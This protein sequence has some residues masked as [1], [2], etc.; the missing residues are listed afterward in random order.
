MSNEI[1]IPDDII[2]SKI[3][4]IRNQ[5]VML[6]KEYNDLIVKFLQRNYPVSRI[7]VNSRFKRA[8]V[9]DDGAYLLSDGESAR[10]LKT[11][12]IQI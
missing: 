10:P 9:L 7:K 1:L 3:Y 4:L 8:I 6:D 2:S 11:K 12:L 5:K